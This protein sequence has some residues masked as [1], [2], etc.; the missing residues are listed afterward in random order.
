MNS[1]TRVEAADAY[2]KVRCYNI[3]SRTK[4]SYR[5]H[6]MYVKENPH[7]VR[8]TD[9]ADIRSPIDKDLTRFDV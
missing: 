1:T 2:G 4:V 5:G 7:Y 8:C 9:G 3:I 6:M